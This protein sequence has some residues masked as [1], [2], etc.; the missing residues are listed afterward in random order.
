MRNKR[1]CGLPILT[2]LVVGFIVIAAIIGGVV[3]G[4]VGSKTGKS[5]SAQTAGTAAAE[6]ET[7]LSGIRLPEPTMRASNSISSTSTSS[8][9]RPTR[10]QAC[11]EFKIDVR[12]DYWHSVTVRPS[13]LS[14]P[15]LPH[16]P[17]KSARPQLTYT[18]SELLRRPHTIHARRI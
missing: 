15:H 6:D 5:N 3:G 12:S 1:L 16:P 4:L 10:T 7:S 11:S 17:Y 9:A 13:L 14:L 8:S 2:A 18:F